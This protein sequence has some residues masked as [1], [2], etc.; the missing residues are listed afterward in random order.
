MPPTP[1]QPLFNTEAA[2]EFLALLGADH[3]AVHF[4]GIHWDKALEPKAARARHLLPAFGSRAP[5]LEALQRQGYR[6][7][8]L[9]NGGPYDRDVLECCYLFVEWDEQPIDWQ[10]QAWQELGLPEPT[11]MVTTGG[12]SIHCYWRLSAPI[13][14]D[15]WRALI[16]R[17]IR[18]CGSDPTCKNPSRLMRLAGSAYI[19]KTDDLAPD[20]ASLGGTIGPAPAAVVRSN[21]AA[22]YPAEL[23]E[24]RLPALQEPPAPVQ[25]LPSPNASTAGTGTVERRSI[26]EITRLVAAYP[27][28]LA[29]NDQREEALRF[30]AGLA[31]VMED[32]G[33]SRADAIA[34]ASS[35]HP[36]AS[37]TFQQVEKWRFDAFGVESFIAQCKRAGVDVKRRDLP[38]REDL[39]RPEEP[40]ADGLGL[41]PPPEP[42]S[43][44]DR[45]LAG[46]AAAAIT[47]AGTR[48]IELGQVLPPGIAGPLVERAAAFPC[49]PMAFLLPLLCA[50]ASVVGNRMDVRVKATWR[51]PFVLWAA[52]VMPASSLKSPIAS[53]ILKP[54]S[55]WQAALNK[56]KQGEKAAYNSSRNQIALQGDKERLSEWESE[57]PPPSPARELFIID[58]TLEKIG[59]MLGQPETCGMVAYHDE[60][61]LWFQQ[62]KR[63][64]DA[65]DQRSNWLSLWTG[66][67][68]KVDRIGRDS[69]Y[70]PNTAQSVFGL[71]TV[72]G[73]RIIQSAGKPSEGNQDA[74]GLWARFLLWQPRDVP[75]VHNDLDRDV[76]DLLLNTFRD[77]IDAL[78]P[79]L[80]EDQPPAALSL[81]AEG[82]AMMAQHWTAWDALA[83]E[84]TKERGQWLGKLRGHSV[85]I[86]G[87]L[88]VLDCAAKDLP[89][90]A[91]VSTDAARR[92]LLLCHALLDQY[93]F[94]HAGIGSEADGLD[95]AVAKLLARGVEWRRTHGNAPVPLEQLRRWKIP[96]RE[97]TAQDR[98]AWLTTNVSANDRLGRVETTARSTA[99]LPPAN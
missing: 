85:R 84:T 68:L 51:E 59:Q 90:I 2:G 50:T 55:K 53:V 15:R 11:A 28:I 30:V 91:D 34:L 58:A 83:R 76:T 32:M 87:L 75:Y 86:A 62:L 49:D 56:T 80:K 52:N 66:G 8:W 39:P 47:A 6:L 74:D 94:L 61:T 12:K 98:Q 67:L 19:Y 26:E 64:K 70:I 38:E 40:H 96:T 93:D 78:V 7:Y 72:D 73:L 16:Q 4:R 10:L 37:D 43:D 65:L 3:A 27:T 24:D 5:Q 45:R 18:Y 25:P 79:A 22:I 23:F 17:L 21:S 36:Q 48:A 14:T 71:S 99:W 63:G 82:I 9:P 42:L 33:R 54:L 88:H 60:L 13:T 31:R 57:N 1:S 89:I 41:P 44:D 81:T 46:E 29:A 92:S 77:R 20:G 97:A 69:I 35:Y 95:P